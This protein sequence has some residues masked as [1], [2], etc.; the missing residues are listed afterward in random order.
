MATYTNT[1]TVSGI[2]PEQ[3]GPLLVEPVQQAAAA[4][5]PRVS[6]TVTTDSHTFHLPVVNVDAAASWVN[7]GAE[8]APT[9]PS[10]S[11]IKVTPS[12]VAGL[13]IISNELA[14]DSSPAAAEV[15]GT[16]LARSIAA[17]IDAAYFGNLT[18][19]APAGMGSFANA[20][21]NRIAAGVTPSNLDSFAQAMSLVELDGSQLTAFVAHPTD[22]L[23]IQNIK[24]GTGYA[25][26][27]LGTDAANGTMRQVLG[28]PMI[29]TPRIPAGTIWG[30]AA[31]RNYVVMRSDAS[32]VTD[33]SVFFT[34]DRVAV[35]GV[36]RVGFGF[37][38]PR[39]IVKISLTAS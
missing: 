6:T 12:K 34:S 22:A 30:V 24:T 17:Q 31:T 19:P 13:T 20:A 3:W 11:E 39:A 26:P 29:V 18:S 4:L 28:V 15:V 9:D 1:P 36:M 2:L 35:R 14:N 32:V 38:T 7:E 8:I 27:L 10:L 33:N 16:G 25:M 23:T 21:I 5:D 37:P